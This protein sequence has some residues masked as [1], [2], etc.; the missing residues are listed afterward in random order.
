[1]AASDNNPAALTA[2]EMQARLAE[3]QAQLAVALRRAQDALAAAREKSL[4]L[5]RV[6][7]ASHEIIAFLH[8]DGRVRSINRAIEAVLGYPP[9]AVVGQ[10]FSEYIHPDDL[11]TTAKAIRTATTGGQVL[12]FQTR[13]TCMDGTLAY[14]EW[15]ARYI[16]EE[17]AVL[18]IGRDVT[19][20][21]QA[22]EAL[23]HQERL[24][25][26]VVDHS[27]DLLGLYGA[28]RK[29]LYLSPSSE[30]GL[31]YTNSEAVAADPLQIAHPD[32]APAVLEAFE[33]AL[34]GK[35]STATYRARSKSGEYLWLEVANNPIFDD[36]GNV[37]Q[38]LCSGRDLGSRQR[39]QEQLTYQA[40]HDPL[41]GLPNRALFMDR[42]NHA[43]AR[44]VRSHQPVAV[45]F[46]DLDNFKLV[47]DSLGHDVGDQLLMAV[48][49]RLRG[50]LR[51]SDTVA[52][53]GGDEFAVLLENMSGPDDAQ[54]VAERI[55][56]LWQTPIDLRGREVYVAFS[57]GIAP[58]L[59]GQDRPE[60]L[61]RNADMAM[62][63]AKQAGKGG[64]ALY[65]PSMNDQTLVRLELSNDLRRALG[66]SEFRLYY[67]PV[68]DLETGS[69]VGMEALLRWQH[70]ERGLVP[71]AAFIPL[72]E[73]TGLILPLGR[74]VLKEACRQA[75]RWQLEF[76]STPS[77]FMCVNLSVRQLHQANLLDEVSSALTETGLAAQDLHLE[78]TESHMMQDAAS[79]LETLHRLKQLGV[80]VA[81]DDFG[82]GYSSLSYLKRF[83]VDILK[84]DRSF[85][86]GLGENP[87]NNAI[88]Q[89]V[90]ALAKALNLTV[91][92]E[93]VETP[94]QL[95]DLRALQCERGQGYYFAK[96]L[97]T[98]E[99]TRL[100]AERP[101]YN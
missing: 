50:C 51:P 14:I 30:A 95:E 18:C 3:L 57:I 52:R 5:Q 73:E 82:T 71:P 72:A 26:V 9:D 91:Q 59:G 87:E 25:R 85:V 37:V 21:R 101:R 38:V 20:R 67:Q 75:R 62:Y 86:G 96:P 32:D 48:G 49:Q 93:G 69:L 60:D 99:L 34:Q 19:Q 6:L 97:P 61:L 68:V 2:L 8:A 56:Q 88:V 22:E 63:R 80:K 78:I 83:P 31:G 90:I 42:L 7:D 4:Q 81:I 94:G 54:Q 29:I 16:P 35:A 33:S 17:E 92:G 10:I 1:M 65:D 39:M 74:W 58:G 24:Y 98:D 11:D 23:R 89:T 47:N 53:L 13:Y 45:M 41:T 77:L 36:Q 64:Y 84:V 100:L 12:G 79:T 40:F 15:N 66:R 70:P 44:G 46:L 28:D 27:S 55:A 43:L 76:P